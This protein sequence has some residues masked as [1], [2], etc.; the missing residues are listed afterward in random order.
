MKWRKK[1]LKSE[2]CQFRVCGCR[3]VV[4][5]KTHQMIFVSII[6]ISFE[7]SH[8]HLSRMS[9]A[10]PHF[11]YKAR[12]HQHINIFV[13]VI[14]HQ[15]SYTSCTIMNTSKLT[16][17]LAYNFIFSFYFNNLPLVQCVFSFNPHEKWFSFIWNEFFRFSF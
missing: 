15:F 10:L 1:R 13:I 11:F 3:E 8:S 5:N 2:S 14:C 6:F 17:W 7:L 16:R 12:D 4:W 9:W